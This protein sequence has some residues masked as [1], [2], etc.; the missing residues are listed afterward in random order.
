[1]QKL[2]SATPIFSIFP[3]IKKHHVILLLLP[4]KKTQQSLEATEKFLE[5]K[6]QIHK[7]H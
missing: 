4:R 1:M 6:L 2:L 3:G 7:K 5:L